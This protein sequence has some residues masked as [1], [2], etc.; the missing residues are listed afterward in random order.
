M[1]NDQIAKQLETLADLLEF[2]GENPFRLRAYR[3]AARA[4]RD[5]S[6]PIEK[7]V[8][9]GVDLT[10]FDGIGDAIAKKCQEL[11]ET[12]H[13][14][15]LDEL[16]Q[17][18][19]RT[20][21]DLLN[22]PKL[23]P[24]KAATLYRELGITDLEQLKAAA[25]TGKIRELP[26]FGA[27]TEQ[28]ILEG[29]KIVAAS[30]KRILWAEADRLVAALKEYLDRCSDIERFEFAG[31]YRRCKET[32]GDLDVLIDS[33]AP[34]VV[35]DQL[36][37]YSDIAT[38]TERGDTKMSVRLTDGFQVDFRVVPATCFGSGLQHFTG[39][40]DHNVILRGMAK[41]LG[42]KI[43]EWG[44]FRVDGER[45]TRIGGEREED[46]YEALSLPWFPPEI[47]EAR[48][49][50]DWAEQGELPRLIQLDDIR[51]DL[52]MHTNATDGQ[53][54][55]EEMVQAAR[56]RGL[57]YIAITDHSKRVSMANGL[58]SERLLD[59]WK[60]IDKLNGKL[61]GK[62]HV[63]KGIECDILEDGTMDLP[64]SVLAK[65]DWVIASLHYGQQQPKAQITDRLLN[66]IRNEH[67]TMIAH[68][69]GRLL[70]R[71]PPYDVDME[72]VFQAALEHGK[73]LELNANP[74]RLDL[75][76]VQLS[77]ARKVGIPIVINTDAHRPSGLDDMRFGINQ[78]RRG[79]LS[80]EHVV[81][82][83]TWRDFKK[84]LKKK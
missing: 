18:T 49:E 7:L 60:T 28:A 79:G 46:V 45:E 78:A 82:T 21:L 80:A 3:R 4:I 39:S 75:N 66:A 20:V 11:V 62:I 43:S 69:T 1:T 52:H 72:A 65:A 54:S 81:N 42:L 15:K 37:G 84:L 27:K 83:R 41:K 35:W 14:S 76:D 17:D 73:L 61:D 56:S 19:P 36:A 44:V 53:A 64:D 70:N 59:Q 68:P 40:K 2:K 13:L 30:G 67:V 9:D 10:Q 22:V 26:G 51:G 38:V 63:L 47:R 24:K 29:I 77:V 55:I 12:G 50:F 8:H 31:S 33:A 34:D 58:D 71:R 16:L 57:Q 5:L 25:E 48:F 32:V 6:E 23:G 74:R